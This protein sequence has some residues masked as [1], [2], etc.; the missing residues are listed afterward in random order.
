M[1]PRVFQDCVAGR[2]TS[3]YSI[4]TTQNMSKNIALL[5]IQEKHLAKF[6]VCVC[7]FL[8]YFYLKGVKMLDPSLIACHCGFQ[9][10]FS[11]LNRR[12]CETA[13]SKRRFF[14]FYPSVRRFGAQHAHTLLCPSSSGDSVLWGS[15]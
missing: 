13:I 6:G 9:N 15:D 7:F 8:Y 11:S 4:P 12:R 14:F 5:N 2:A 10:W 3:I 1:I